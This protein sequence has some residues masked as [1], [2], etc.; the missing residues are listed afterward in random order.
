VISADPSRSWEAAVGTFPYTAQEI[1]LVKRCTKK[2][3]PRLTLDFK[4]HSSSMLEVF[5][6][7]Q[8]DTA[9]CG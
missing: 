1:L 5:S 8:Q 4:K 3:S 9:H 2:A 7:R 6:S